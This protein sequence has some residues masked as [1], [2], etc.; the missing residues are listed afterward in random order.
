MYDYTCIVMYSQHSMGSTCEA[1]RQ[2]SAC[3]KK[4]TQRE[5]KLHLRSPIRMGKGLQPVGAQEGFIGQQI[6]NA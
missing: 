2:V 3:K 4:A 6:Q 5:S 1:L